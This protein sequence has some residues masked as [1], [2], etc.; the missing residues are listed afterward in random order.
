M[1]TIGEALPRVD[2]QGARDSYTRRWELSQRPYNPGRQESFSDAVSIRTESSG[3]RSTKGKQLKFP[4]CLPTQPLSIIIGRTTAVLLVGAL[5]TELNSSRNAEAIDSYVA[6]IY[7]SAS[8]SYKEAHKLVT[9]GAVPAL[10][11]LLK[12]RAGEAEGLEIVLITLGT[13]A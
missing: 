12:T 2:S 9:A 6:K 8:E 4:P 5:Q 11:H 10:I 3:S 1:T 13:L 7:H